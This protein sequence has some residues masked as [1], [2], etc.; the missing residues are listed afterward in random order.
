MTDRILDDIPTLEN[1][2]ARRDEI[3]ALAAKRRAFNVRV[4]GSVARGDATPESDIDL[5]VKFEDGA[6]LYDLSGLWQDLC[7]LLG[8]PVDILEEHDRMRERLRKNIFK[9][10][11]PL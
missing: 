1:L 11:V 6:S 10:A 2:R 5:L 9:D 4:F 7:E 3:I 8:R